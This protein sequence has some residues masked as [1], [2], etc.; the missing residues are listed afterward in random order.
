MGLRYERRAQEYL[1]EVYPDS[2]VPSPWIAFRLRYEPLLRYCQP[3]GLLVDIEQGRV[4]IIEIKYRH[5]VEAYVQLT[6]I[7]DPVVKKLFPGWDVR[8]VEMARWYD[9][10]TAFPV[11]VQLLSCI[12]LAAK[13]RF[14][15]HIWNP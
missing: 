2:Y 14:G 11:P 10:G 9:P 3:D 1:L 13:G 8:H 12:D 5:M 7:Y 4:T 15:V 6:G